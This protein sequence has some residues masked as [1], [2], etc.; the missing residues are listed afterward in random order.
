M[1]ERQGLSHLSELSAFSAEASGESPPGRQKK[2]ITYCP[3]QTK[4]KGED[5]QNITVPSGHITIT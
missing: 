1:E 2:I 5:S 3:S 4:P